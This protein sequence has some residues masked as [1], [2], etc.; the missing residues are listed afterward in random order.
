ME[1]YYRFNFKTTDVV[2]CRFIFV[3]FVYLKKN[4]KYGTDLVS[5]NQSETIKLLI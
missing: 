4:R 5:F 1:Y 3:L 2:Y